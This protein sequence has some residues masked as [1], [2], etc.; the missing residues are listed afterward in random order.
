MLSLITHYSECWI[1]TVSTY[2]ISNLS[3]PIDRLHPT[4]ATTYNKRPENTKE[5]VCLPVSGE[6]F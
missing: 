1:A 6:T 2:L 5:P 4:F 3:T